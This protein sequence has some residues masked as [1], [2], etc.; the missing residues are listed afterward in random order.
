MMRL[1][2]KI[3]QMRPFLKDYWPYIL[4]IAWF[5]AI[6]IA[7]AIVSYWSGVIHSIYSTIFMYVIMCQERTIRTLNRVTDILIKGFI[8]VTHKSENEKQQT[9]Q[10]P[11]EGEGDSKE[12]R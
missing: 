2:F 9:F 12:I 11:E 10:H 4:I 1:K 5:I 8:K 3:S 7:D 6:A